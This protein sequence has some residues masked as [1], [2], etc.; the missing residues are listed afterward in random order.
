MNTDQ[1]T[2]AEKSK[3]HLHGLDYLRVFFMIMVLLGHANFFMEMAVNRENTTGPGQNFWDYL[4]FQ[5]QAVGVPAFV[6][7]SMLLFV[8]KPPT[9]ARTKDRVVKLSY[10]YIFW[11]GAWMYVTRPKIELNVWAVLELVLRGGGWLYYT[12]ATL[13]VLTPVCW[14]ASKLSRKGLWCGLAVSAGIVA[15]TFYYAYQEYRFVTKPV[16]W[17][18]TCFCM[19]PFVA[20]LLVPRLSLFCDLPRMRYKWAA[21][22]I[23]L[24]LL[25]SALE[26]RFAVPYE[27]IGEYRSWIPKFARI[28]V[29]CSAVA[30]LLLALGIKHPA[31]RIVSFF[32]R[33]SLG[34]YC[35]H[36]FILGGIVRNT[37][38]VIPD[39]IHLFALPIACFITAL[40][41]SLLAELLRKAFKQRLI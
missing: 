9:W 34:V 40:F 33:N 23:G 10:L 39:S 27:L 31:N 14:L 30:L 35:I 36:P 22:C 16:Y 2:S 18:P 15:G 5:V 29:H 28:S 21:F 38:A 7:M 12:F 25:F 6:L 1:T 13:I 26:W 3:I 24:G 17:M 11:V 4:F 37:K 20:L 19:M 41:S 32:S 8:V